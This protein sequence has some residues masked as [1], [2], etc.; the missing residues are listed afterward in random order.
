MNLALSQLA[1]FAVGDIAETVVVIPR[2]LRCKAMVQHQHF[3]LWPK[4]HLSG[5]AFQWTSPGHSPLSDMLLT[6]VSH[7]YKSIEQ[8][9]QSTDPQNWLTSFY[10][11]LNTCWLRRSRFRLTEHRE[12][13]SIIP[14]PFHQSPLIYFA[15]RILKKGSGFKTHNSP[16]QR[17]RAL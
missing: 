14:F 12:E 3:P 15:R 7:C 10:S 16:L 4:L 11:T 8:H 2:F 13:R 6:S 5:T 17:E 1:K 9:R